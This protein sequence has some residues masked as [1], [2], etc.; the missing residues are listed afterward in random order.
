MEI[1]GTQTNHKNVEIKRTNFED[2]QMQSTNNQNS[3]VLSQGHIY[4]SI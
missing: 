3:M 2:S 4:R 1:H